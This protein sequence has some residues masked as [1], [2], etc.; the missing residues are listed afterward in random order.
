M[1]RTAVACTYQTMPAQHVLAH[2]V[3]E[4]IN[5]FKRR[6]GEYMDVISFL[7]FLG[8]TLSLIGIAAGA[9][10]TL[11][12]TEPLNGGQK[13]QPNARLPHPEVHEPLNHRLLL[14]AEW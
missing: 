13:V 12:A 3:A 2:V 5:Y 4:V 14:E 7:W 6:Q 9:V 1:V 8:Q 11:W 10:L